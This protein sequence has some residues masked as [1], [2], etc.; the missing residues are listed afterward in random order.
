MRVCFKPE[1]STPTAVPGQ[2]TNS[3][4]TSVWPPDAETLRRKSFALCKE[5]GNLKSPTTTILT[6]NTTRNLSPCI[7]PEITYRFNNN[8]NYDQCNL[9]DD[10]MNAAESSYDSYAFKTEWLVWGDS[11]MCCCLFYNLR[12]KLNENICYSEVDEALKI[13][14]KKM[15]VMNKLSIILSCLIVKL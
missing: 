3:S 15:L 8:F 4:G 10:L 11:K 6:T 12:S 5:Y 2:I 7:R 9:Q 14:N 1:R 13:E